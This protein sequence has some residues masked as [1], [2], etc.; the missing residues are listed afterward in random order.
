MLINGALAQAETQVVKLIDKYGRNREGLH[1][2]DFAAAERP[3]NGD[4]SHAGR[5]LPRRVG[6]RLGRHDR[7][8]GLGEGRHDL[9]KTTNSLSTSTAAI[10]K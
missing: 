2:G 3:L 4:C 8:A 10:P 9:G 7:Q 5:C 1:D 6:R